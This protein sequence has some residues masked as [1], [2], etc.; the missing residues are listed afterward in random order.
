MKI[1]PVGTIVSHA[2]RQTHWETGMKKTL[3][4]LRSFAKLL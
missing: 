4:V 3:V 2:D 1:R